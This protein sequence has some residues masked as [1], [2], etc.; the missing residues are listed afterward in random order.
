VRAVLS[1]LHVGQPEICNAWNNVPTAHGLQITVYAHQRLSV[2]QSCA[3][4]CHQMI[5]RTLRTMG[6]TLKSA[7]CFQ[8]HGQIFPAYTCA[9]AVPSLNKRV[10][11]YIAD[12]SKQIDPRIEAYFL[13]PESTIVPIVDRSLTNN[14]P[15]SVIPSSFSTT[16]AEQIDNFDPTTTIPR[17]MRAAGIATDAFRL[18][19]SYRHLDAASIASQLFHALSE[20]MFDTFLDRFSSRT[21]DDFV[22]LVQEELFDKSCILVLETDGIGGSVYCRTEVATATANFLGLMA[23][24]LPGSRQVFTGVPTRFDLTGA[25]LRPNG[26]LDQ[27]D[28]NNL[29]EFI[30]ANYDDQVARRPRAQDQELLSSIISAGL[31][32]NPL[33]VG[34]YRV[35]N[36]KDYVVSMSRRP[37]GVDDFIQI[38]RNAANPSSKKVLFGPISVVRTQRAEQINWLGDKSGTTT[39]DEGHVQRSLQDIAAGRL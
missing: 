35:N 12:G 15:Q 11:V 30:E 24:D 28:L 21:G 36:G 14:S 32:P 29:I 20:R 5:E 31:Y 33:G 6:G 13:T 34:E 37:P 7:P 18:F 4:Q 10:L 38:E 39:I 22:S 17:I 27:Y 2:A 9:G 25:T 3:W 1:Q 8:V 26:E 16:I 19:I 23:V